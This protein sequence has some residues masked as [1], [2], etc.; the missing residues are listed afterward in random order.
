MPDQRDKYVS[1]KT[2]SAG[3]IKK[4]NQNVASPINYFVQKGLLQDL[5]RLGI[6][7]SYH[8]EQTDDHVYLNTDRIRNIVSPADLTIKS[9]IQLSLKILEFEKNLNRLNCRLDD[10]H[11]WNFLLINKS[12]KLVDLGAMEFE[13]IKRHWVNNDF[14]PQRKTYERLYINFIFSQLSRNKFYMYPTYRSYNEKGILDMPVSVVFNPLLLMLFIYYK[15]STVALMFLKSIV[16]PMFLRKVYFKNTRLILSL[17][18]KFNHTKTHIHNK[19]PDAVGQK[20]KG[21][22]SVVY[23]DFVLESSTNIK[24]DILLSELPQKGYEDNQGNSVLNFNFTDPSPSSGPNLCWSR[25]IFER[26]S[27]KNALFILDLDKQIGEKSLI[28]SDLLSSIFNFNFR[29]VE[30]FMHFSGEPNSELSKVGNVTVDR[31]SLSNQIDCMSGQAM[32][33]SINIEYDEIKNTT[34]VT[35]FVKQVE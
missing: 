31:T 22:F 21:D 20:I 23:S 24:C 30:I 26:I 18:L 9:F 29:E 8:I 6:I 3:H 4:I 19:F 10:I 14:W 1:S 28:V 35:V 12:F 34:L 11:P 16:S 33:K 25:S 5:S 17:L 7:Q 13:S 2:T 32:S 15:L 27:G